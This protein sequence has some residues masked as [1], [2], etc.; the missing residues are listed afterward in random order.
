MSGICLCCSF[1]YRYRR[2]PPFQFSPRVAHWTNVSAGVVHTFQGEYWGNWQFSIASLDTATATLSFGRGGWQEAR[3]AAFGAALFVEGILEELD[4]PGEWLWV[5]DVPSSG[6]GEGTLYLWY[7]ASAGTPPPPGAVLVTQV[8]RLVTLTGNTTA[9]VVGVTL[10]GL[11][12]TASQPTFIERP[13]RA[14]SGGDWSFAETAAIVAEGTASFSIDGCVF[15]RLGGNG[16]LLRGSNADTAITNSSF[17]LLGDSG[18][19]S[20]GL[21]DLADLSSAQVSE[22]RWSFYDVTVLVCV[23]VTDYPLPTAPA[24]SDWHAR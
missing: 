22:N 13:F 20:C 17:S 6:G 1:T 24:G 5:P 23:K 4:A 10:S 12:F 21:A 9:P 16:I 14:P 3:G 19:V 11:T 8:E 15:V 2:A 18:I 7:N